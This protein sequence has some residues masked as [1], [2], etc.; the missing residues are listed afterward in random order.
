MKIGFV[1]FAII[2]LFSLNGYI[3]VRGWQALPS[4]SL[5]RPIYLVTAILLFIALFAGMILE[6]SM[7]QGIAKAVSLAGFTYLIIFIYSIK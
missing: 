2:I 5:F 7:P 3:M 1:I 6:N 4:A